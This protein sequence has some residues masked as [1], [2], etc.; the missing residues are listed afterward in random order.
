MSDADN[1]FN[2]E[3]ILAR[4]L[5]DNDEVCYFLILTYKNNSVKFRAT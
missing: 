1:R 5:I 2:V 4:K 3:K